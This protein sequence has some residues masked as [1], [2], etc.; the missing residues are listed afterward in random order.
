MGPRVNF[1]TCPI[2]LFVTLG[3]SMV[4]VGAL[5][6]Q[7]GQTF[8]SPL[9]KW[10]VLEWPQMSATSLV[11]HCF[12][13]PQPLHLVAVTIALLWAGRLLEARW[14]SLR[15]AIFYVLISI[16]SALVGVFILEIGNVMNPERAPE[17]QHPI[18]LFGGGAVA[19][20]CLAVASKVEPDRSLLHWISS[21]YLFWIFIVLGATGLVVLET[22]VFD[23]SNPRLFLLPQLSGLPFGLIFQWALPRIDDMLESWAAARRRAAERE[24]VKMRIRVDQLLDKI[25]VDGLDSLSSEERSFLRQASKHYKG[26]EDL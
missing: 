25:N 21:H 6:A 14:G 24:L 17:L 26:P 23:E 22:E 16:S 9:A 12:F 15:F 11:L 1:A 20:A 5:V 3:N 2:V 7:E 10:M 13:H 8:Q 4:L 18:A 19:M